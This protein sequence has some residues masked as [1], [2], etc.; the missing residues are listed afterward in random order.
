MENK[1]YGREKSLALIKEL[2]LA[3]GPT[4]CEEPVAELI[5]KKL[6]A[7]HVPF[8]RDRMGNVIARLRFGKADGGAESLERQRIMVSAHMDEVGFMITEVDGDG[9]LRID[10]VGG[11][12][13]SVM[14]GRRVLVGDGK[15]HMSGLIASTAIHH[16]KKDERSKAE[17]LEKLYIDI[18]A[19][20]REEASGYAGVGSFA[21]FDSEFYTFGKGDSFIKSKAL[22]D[23]MGCAAMLE[24]I[25]S[26][27]GEELYVDADVY[28]CFTVREEIG[29][30]GA[31]CAANLI[32]PHLAIVLETTAVGDIEGASPEKRV[33]E[34]GEG[35]CVSL[36]DRSTIYG[37][38]ETDLALRVA[39]EEGI[40]LQVKKYVSGGNDAGSI[41]K[42]GGGV[43]TVALS[44]PTRYLHSPACVANIEDYMSQ[45]D[46]VEA[47]IRRSGEYFSDRALTLSKGK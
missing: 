22:D 41:H 6:E 10:T 33:A 26:L 29:L 11:I 34:L 15:R 2:C 7:L 9:D 30:S 25:E 18:G 47:M 37:R 46:M 16:K 36:M 39:K 28:F 24:V 35:V 45:R 40:A 14:A 1:R 19:T 32:R 3:F 38:A 42:S 5:E 12:D 44:V 13:G 8:M 4:G 23:R 21:T 20:D 27:A 17:K 31:L 43:R